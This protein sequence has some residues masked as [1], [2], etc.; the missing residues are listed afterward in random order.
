ML[1]RWERY[2]FAPGGRYSIAILRIAIALAVWASLDK[3]AASWIDQSTYRPIGLWMLVGRHAPGPGVVDALWVIARL[4]TIAMAFGAL[5]RLATALSFVSTTLLASLY[6]SAFPAWAHEYNVVL[7]A[8]LAL[9][10]GRCGDALSI[11]ALVWRGRRSEHGYQWSIRLVQI[12][13]ASMFVSAVFHKLRSGGL[14]WALSDNLRN[15][16]VVQFDANGLE[17]TPIAQWLIDDAWKWR[18]AALANLLAQGLPLAACIFVRRPLVRLAC[19]VMFAV[20]VI[21]LGLVMGLWNLK[22]LPLAVVFID[23]E[24]VVRWLPRESADVTPS[25]RTRRVISAF[26]AVFVALVLV[27]SFVRGVDQRLNLYPFTGYPMFSSVRARP[28]YDRHAPYSFEGGQVEIVA[29]EPVPPAIEVELTRYYRK[30]FRIRDR[31]QMRSHM[32]D[33]LASARRMFAPTTGVRVYYSLNEV[34]AYPEPARLD[35]I[36]IALL[37]ELDVDGT[38]HSLLGRAR[39]DGTEIELTP[40]EPVTGS[41]SYYADALPTPHPLPGLRARRPNGRAVAYVLDDGTRRWLIDQA[42]R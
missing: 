35:R 13:V 7:L 18:A 11:D 5:S 27:T 8:H 39:Y 37:G 15:Q 30:L 19:G 4:S 23:W 38:F 10:G 24:W 34:P 42:R 28:P 41:V 12:A 33:I 17:R 29:S 22:W 3:M 36:P 20:E 31:E 32:G 1:R 9:L 16:L 40:G 25:P 14:D 2:W 6:Y 21:A 26:V